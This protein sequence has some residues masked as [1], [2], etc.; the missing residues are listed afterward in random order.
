MPSAG[1]RAMTHSMT[2][3]CVFFVVLIALVIKG[4][5]MK[6]TPDRSALA[7]L[8]LGAGIVAVSGLIYLLSG[9]VLPAELLTLANPPTYKLTVSMAGGAALAT[10]GLISLLINRLKR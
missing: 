1:V 2:F 5:R 8:L 7:V 6:S 3:I 10:Y 9:T 4:R